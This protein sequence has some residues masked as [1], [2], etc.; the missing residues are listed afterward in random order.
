MYPPQLS[1]AFRES[2]LE[3]DDLSTFIMERIEI[4][5]PNIELPPEERLGKETLMDNILDSCITASWR[6]I[7]RK[8]KSKG[9][10]YCGVRNY[11]YD[12]TN[13]EGKVTRQN[14]TKQGAFVNCRLKVISNETRC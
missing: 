13:D 3:F 7:R 5:G 4:L 2:V 10:V 1:Y 6:V 12:I 11:W 9:G 8:I 14:K